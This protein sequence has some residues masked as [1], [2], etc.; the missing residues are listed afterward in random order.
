[1]LREG[2]VG[3]GGRS[4]SRDR[5]TRRWRTAA[6]LTPNTLLRSAD[7]KTKTTPEPAV[8]ANDDDSSDPSLEKETGDI[9]T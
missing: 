2:F 7:E 3:I 4:Q 1:M 5:V 8:V 6:L 9:P